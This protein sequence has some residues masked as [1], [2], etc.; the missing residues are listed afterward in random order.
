MSRHPVRLPLGVSPKDRPVGFRTEASSI[1][2]AK[3]T[4]RPY[5]GA[6]ACLVQAYAPKGGAWR[7]NKNNHPLGNGPW[8]QKQRRK[9]IK[10]LYE[11]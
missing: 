8:I 3:P 4:G 6:T 7:L 2:S 5:G 1:R 10:V 9:M 11:K